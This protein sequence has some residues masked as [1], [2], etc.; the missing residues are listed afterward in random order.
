MGASVARGSAR[1]DTMEW[2][3]HGTVGRRKHETG[4]PRPAWRLALHTF[5]RAD[6]PLTLDMVQ[7]DE[8]WVRSWI[9]AKK[10]GG[11]V[12]APF[13]PYP[14]RLRAYQGYPNKNASGLH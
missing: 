9:T 4:N 13:Q 2:T 11:P 14:K 8:K 7:G 3:P 6:A 12:C 10:A 1:V 5:T